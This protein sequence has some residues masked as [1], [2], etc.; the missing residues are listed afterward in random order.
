MP[1]TRFHIPYIL[2]LPGVELV[3]VHHLV[4]KGDSVEAMVVV[5]EDEAGGARHHH[6]RQVL[7][8]GMPVLVE[9]SEGKKTMV[10]SVVD[11]LGV[12]YF[13]NLHGPYTWGGSLHSLVAYTPDSSHKSYMIQM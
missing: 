4:E 13:T 11:G 9:G 2:V 1:K 12:S 6:V 7:I 10:T 5:L 3:L 8:L